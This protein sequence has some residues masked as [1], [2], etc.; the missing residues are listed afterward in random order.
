MSHQ[1]PLC[2]MFCRELRFAVMCGG[3]TKPILP[4]EEGGGGAPIPLEQQQQPP[5]ADEEQVQVSY[6]RY[7]QYDVSDI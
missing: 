4:K 5:P 6:Y 7:A 3:S 1:E 2:L